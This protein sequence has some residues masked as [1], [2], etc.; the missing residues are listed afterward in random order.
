MTLK[1]LFGIEDDPEIHIPGLEYILDYISAPEHQKLIE[2]IDIQPW[3]NDLKRR[4]QHYGYKYDYKAR[5]IDQ[6]MYL[7]SLPDW[8]Q[9]LA[10]KLHQDGIFPDIPDQVIVNQYLPGQGISAH[11]DCVPCFGETIVSLSLGSAAM[12][13]LTRP[14]TNERQEIYL[15]PCSLIALSGPARYDWQH[16][17]PAR[18]SDI[19]DGVKIS[20]GRRVSLTFRKTIL[21]N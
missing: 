19:I 17:I 12:M 1:F 11:I 14:R 18:K 8:L 6:S 21:E 2:I 15:E 3:L 9:G 16:A 5:A 13:Q 7:G 4:V 10:D 20:R